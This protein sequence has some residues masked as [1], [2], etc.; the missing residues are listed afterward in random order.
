MNLLMSEFQNINQNRPFG[1][2][3]ITLL[4]AVGLI[5]T[6]TF[7]YF[8]WSGV[9]PMEPGDKAKLSNFPL[10]NLVAS[11]IVV[12]LNTLAVGA[13]FLLRK[14]ALNLFLSALVLSLAFQAWQTATKGWTAGVGQVGMSGIVLSY[15][16]PILVC[17][18]TWRL[19]KKGI[20]L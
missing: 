15:A 7:L 9:V 13:L 6:L 12:L 16:I 2:W 19:I 18:Y 5:L 14:N 20:L 17:I 11:I 8:I 1:I 4:Y 3:L 10:V